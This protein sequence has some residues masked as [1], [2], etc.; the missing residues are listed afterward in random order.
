MLFLVYHSTANDNEYFL[1]KRNLFR[2]TVE[3]AIVLNYDIINDVMM[4]CIYQ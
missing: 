2:E 4:Q 3:K 1:C